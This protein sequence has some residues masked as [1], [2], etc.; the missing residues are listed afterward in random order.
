MHT[1]EGLRITQYLPPLAVW[2]K[3]AL[4]QNP[5][6]VLEN[7]KPTLKYVTKAGVA[8]SIE[9]QN[10][11]PFPDRASFQNGPQSFET[12]RPV[13]LIQEYFDPKMKFDVKIALSDNYLTS[14]LNINNPTDKL[15]DITISSQSLLSKDEGKWKS[16]Q[17]VF[18]NLTDEYLE[19]LKKEKLVASNAKNTILIRRTDDGKITPTIKGDLDGPELLL[20]DDILKK[21]YDDT[22]FFSEFDKEGTM[23]LGTLKKMVF[24]VYHARNTAIDPEQTL[25]ILTGAHPKEKFVFPVHFVSPVQHKSASLA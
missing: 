22:E 8:N 17:I 25:K 24:N 18:L 7:A 16:S 20:P 10:M 15:S 23:T 11:S 5:N 13:S 14:H 2:Y 3:L 6:L 19:E 9:F 21:I 4:E 1:A 12:Y